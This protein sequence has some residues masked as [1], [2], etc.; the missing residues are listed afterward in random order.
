MT[1]SELFWAI[2]TAI[3]ESFVFFQM[4]ENKANYLFI[5]VGLVMGLWW[6]YKLMQYEKEAERDGTML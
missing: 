3:E 5:V 1:F 4:A 2:G 6:V